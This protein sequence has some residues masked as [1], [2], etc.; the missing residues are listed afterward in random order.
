[1]ALLVLGAVL[2]VVAVLAAAF[3]ALCAELY[4]RL[5]IPA[6]PSFLDDFGFTPWE[7]QVNYEDVDLVTADGVSFGAWFFRQSGS[8]QVIVISPGHKGRRESLLGI[9]VALWRKGFNVLVYSYRGMPG[10]DRTVVTMGVR[11][12][13]ELESAIA[14][15]RRRVRGARIGLLGY[16]MG[17]VVSLLGAAGDPSVEALVL[18][19]PFSDLRRVVR[20]NI[21]R[22]TLLPGAPFV[23]AVGLWLR[24]RHGV[25][26]SE[27]SPI[28]VLSGLESRPV[29]FIHGGADGI[30]SVQ[31]SRLL[32]DAY[33]GP[34]E[35][36]VVQGA[37][38]TGAYFA[39]RQLYLERVAGF[40]ARNL[41]LK[42]AGQLRLVE[43]DD[44]EVS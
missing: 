27:S 3:L 11:E 28:A 31:H 14:F 10:S 7:F 25:R 32:H 6:R 5:F 1:M 43:D 29:F 17:A 40:F 39:D 35:I 30:T 26:I 4:R 38:H 24:L 37:P 41:G 8:P 2:A 20:E 16:S 15:A 23:M 22:Y 34:R 18:D 42:A 44:E 9:A 12:V 33:K 36:W 13:Q 19:S 21:R